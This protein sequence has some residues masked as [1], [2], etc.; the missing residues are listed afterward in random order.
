MEVKIGVQHSPR[1]LIIAGTGDPA[2][3]GRLIDRITAAHTDRM[4]KL[5]LNP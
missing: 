1:E 4:K 5:G 3:I 2:G